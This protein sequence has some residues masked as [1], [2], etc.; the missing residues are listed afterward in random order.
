[1]RVRVPINSLKAG[2]DLRQY[3]LKDIRRILRIAHNPRDNVYHALF[4]R[5]DQSFIQIIAFA[6]FYHPIVTKQLINLAPTY[7]NV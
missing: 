7:Y 6:H 3:L 5:T 1:M 4:Y 2:P